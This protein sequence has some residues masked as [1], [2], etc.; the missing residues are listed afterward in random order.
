MAQFEEKIK[1]RFKG[2][3]NEPYKCEVIGLPNNSALGIWNG[4]LTIPTN[5]LR[6]I[7]KEVTDRVVRLVMDQIYATMP[8]QVTTVVLAGGLGANEY[9]ELELERAI[10]RAGLSAAVKHV[11]NRS[12][13]AVL[14]C[15]MVLPTLA[16]Y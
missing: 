16:V 6:A 1:K 12:V 8:A 7:F 4:R 11:M 10:R 2:S 3:A 15:Q 14:H 9:L 5:E 13:S